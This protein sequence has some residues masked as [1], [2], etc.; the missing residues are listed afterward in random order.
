MKNYLMSQQGQ[1]QAPVKSTNFVRTTFKQEEGMIIQAM[2]AKIKGKYE[3]K[4]K[5]EA[6]WEEK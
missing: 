2:E 1:I 6:I 4:A 3:L 5:L